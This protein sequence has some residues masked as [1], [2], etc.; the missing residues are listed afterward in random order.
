MLTRFFFLLL[1]LIF[2]LQADEYARGKA[3]FKEKCSSCH[4]G[5]ISV[6]RIKKNFFEMN[7]TLLHLK[8]PS[9]N[10]LAYAITE[11]P[12][13][14]GD[15]NDPEMRQEEIE[16]YLKEYLSHPDLD[17]SICEPTVMKHYEKKP[18]LKTPLSDEEYAA[19][20]RYFLE[21]KK[22][23]QARNTT[24]AVRTLS[25]FSDEKSILQEAQKRKKRIIIEAE[26]KTCHYCKEMKKEVIDDREVAQALRKDFILLSVDV[27][28]SK[29]PFNLGKSYRHITPSFFFLDSQGRLMNHY[30]G[31]WKKHDFLQI[32][33]ENRNGK[34]EE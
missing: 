9:V 33:K 22:R 12:K 18:A 11:G 27:G 32:L 26:S 1:F 28:E 34:S 23:Y 7:N 10:M 19:L 5:H 6:D 13:K 3:L 30:P 4:P 8:A 15:P 29:L 16:E 24:P 31:S 20:A 21:Y 2:G 17:D 25:E 14:I